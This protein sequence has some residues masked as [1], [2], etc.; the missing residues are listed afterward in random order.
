MENPS[1]AGSIPHNEF[2]EKQKRVLKTMYKDLGGLVPKLNLITLD[3]PRAYPEGSDEYKLFRGELPESISRAIEEGKTFKGMTN[4]VIKIPELTPEFLSQF[5]DS[6]HN[7]VD[8]HDD[9]YKGTV[10]KYSYTDEIKHKTHRGATNVGYQIG[11]TP[12]HIYLFK[13]FNY[14]RDFNESEKAEFEELLKFYES[15]W[16][17]QR[18][19]IYEKSLPKWIKANQEKI[20][21][22]PKYSRRV[23]NEDFNKIKKLNEIINN[24]DK[25]SKVDIIYLLDIINNLIFVFGLLNAPLQ[26]QLRQINLQFENFK[27]DRLTEEDKKL[28]KE[29]LPSLALIIEDLQKNITLRRNLFRDNEKFTK[30]APHAK[31]IEERENLWVKIETDESNFDTLYALDNRLR[32]GIM[33]NSEGEYMGFL[34][35]N[36]YGKVK[37]IFETKKNQ[38]GELIDQLDHLD[39]ESKKKVIDTIQVWDLVNKTNLDAEHKILYFYEEKDKLGDTDT[40]DKEYVV[41]H[42]NDSLWTFDHYRLPDPKIGTKFTEEEKKKIHYE[43]VDWEGKDK[44]VYEVLPYNKRQYI[45]GFE[46]NIEPYFHYKSLFRTDPFLDFTKYNENVNYQN[47]VFYSRLNNKLISFCAKESDMMFPIKFLIPNPNHVTGKKDMFSLQRRTP[48]KEPSRLLAYQ[49]LGIVSFKKKII[50]KRDAGEKILIENNGF[51]ILKNL[52]REKVE[53]HNH[54]GEYSHFA[55]LDF[56]LQNI[57]K[58]TLSRI[59]NIT[60]DEFNTIYKYL[61]LPMYILTESE[62]PKSSELVIFG[63]NKKYEIPEEL[64]A[65]LRPF[66]LDDY[67]KFETTYK[68]L[69]TSENFSGFLIS[70]DNKDKPFH[71]KLSSIFEP[72]IHIN[73][74]GGGKQFHPNYIYNENYRHQSLR[75]EVSNLIVNN[76]DRLSLDIHDFYSLFYPYLLIRSELIHLVRSEKL[77]DLFLFDGKK[78]INLEI[79]ELLMNHKLIQ[80]NIDFL[81]IDNFSFETISTINFLA[82]KKKIKINSTI[83]LFSKYPYIYYSLWIKKIKQE[84]SDY[85]K[86]I[87]ASNLHIYKNDITKEILNSDI[88]YYDLIINTLDLQNPQNY[89]FREEININLKFISMI[90]AILRLKKKG[91]IIIRYGDITLDQSYQ[92]INNFRKYFKEII[93]EVPTTTR[94]QDTYTTYVIFKEFK[95]DFKIKEFD[96]LINKIFKVDPTLG[97]NFMEN[98]K[99]IKP[100]DK[101]NR[102]IPY[103]EYKKTPNLYLEDYSIEKKMDKN[104]LE[105]ILESEKKKYMLIKKNCMVIKPIVHKFLDTRVSREE[106]I[107]YNNYFRIVCS[108]YKGLE[109]KLFDNEFEPYIKKVEKKLKEPRIIRKVISDYITFSSKESDVKINTEIVETI[110]E[111]NGTFNDYHNYNI[112]ELL[113]YDN[114]LD[115]IY[116]YLEGYEE[117]SI[118]Y[119]E[120]EPYTIDIKTS[121]KRKNI[122][123]MTNNNK[124]FINNLLTNLLNEILEISNERQFIN[125]HI[126]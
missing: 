76:E 28:F 26:Y 106:I 72:S 98:N 96:I 51:L 63:H 78:N 24:L 109:L 53:F 25:A 84:S 14:E 27:R 31:E 8:F 10:P 120:K 52:Q 3:Q 1:V 12:F 60:W 40:P 48:Q 2:I 44:D 49:I 104:L 36:S 91:N 92:I 69:Y 45:Y 17:E 47:L 56:R 101:S 90:Y 16:T 34:S 124:N 107:K 73:L 80:K 57:D 85:L 54:R 77:S 64:K 38:F 113:D 119:N 83:Q 50:K 35:E 29:S 30:L 102:I 88:K 32:H 94:Y 22:L 112:Y 115:K 15:L 70:L 66:T 99:H 39:E 97:F 21:R 33:K 111:F 37:D 20:G 114:Y 5:K 19:E 43:F 42:C 11:N 121:K 55:F 125:Y 68:Q 105:N 4:R 61:K 81:Q 13:G 86:N 103:E 95:G 79:L 87:E 116:D 23:N 93:I 7:L 6:F 108:Y 74:T 82:N 59:M 89:Y 117:V 123:K 67:Y 75:A 122:K 65:R 62:D 58:Y 71:I 18:K 41:K 110:K 46:K 126:K 100:W 9:F 118:E